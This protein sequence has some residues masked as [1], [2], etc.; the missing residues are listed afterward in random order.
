MEDISAW[1][2]TLFEKIERNLTDCLD[3]E[4][5]SKRRLSG[6]DV[7]YPVPARQ[8]DSPPLSRRKELRSHPALPKQEPIQGHVKLDR[9]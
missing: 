2:P 5:G 4:R 9:P 8:T 1:F 6:D 7:R 3:I